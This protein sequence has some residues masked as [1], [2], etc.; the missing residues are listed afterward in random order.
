MAYPCVKR[1]EKECDGCMSCREPVPLLQD[2]P[3]PNCGSVSYT[4]Q[5]MDGKL[6]V[7]CDRC[8]REVMA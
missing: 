8:I 7:G 5:Y 4:L 6:W 2:T 3:C 1:Q